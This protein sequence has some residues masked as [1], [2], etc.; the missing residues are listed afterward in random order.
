MGAPRPVHTKPSLPERIARKMREDILARRKPE[1]RLPTVVELAAQYGASKHSITNALEIL[2]RSGLIS[3]RQRRGIVVTSQGPRWRVGLLSELNLL[4]HRIGSYLRAVA[5]EVKSQLEI[6]GVE[7]RLY[8]GNTVPGPVKQDEPTCPQFWADVAAGR[9]DGAVLLDVPASV[10]WAGRCRGCPIPTVGD[11]SGYEVRINT[12]AIIAAAVRRLAEQGCRRLGMLSW[13]VSP[14]P[15]IDTVNACGLV[16]RDTWIRNDIEP[17]LRGAG[18]DEFREIWSSRERPDGLVV[19]DDMLFFDLQLAVTEAGVRVPQ[20]LKLA[21]QTNR[22]ISPPIRLPVAAFEIDPA[23][24]AAHYVDFLMKRLRGEPIAPV[25]R[26][27]SFREIPT[28]DGR[29]LS[30][31]RPARVKVSNGLNGG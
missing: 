13:I 3:K 8:I 29:P 5:A 12:Q 31:A 7:T 16:T 19:L 14:H 9:L 27:L 23:E 28:G 21:V 4:D 10:A 11:W 2:S 25:T 20:D 22:D 6:L 26:R 18:W 30:A 1:D 15:F 17:S 24:E